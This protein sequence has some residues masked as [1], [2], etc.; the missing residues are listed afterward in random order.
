MRN[1][2]E[3]WKCHDHDCPEI[4][5]V[6]GMNLSLQHVATLRLDTARKKLF[7]VEHLMIWR[8]WRTDG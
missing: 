5:N 8:F 1:N 7:E 4:E 2:A 3:F 6:Q